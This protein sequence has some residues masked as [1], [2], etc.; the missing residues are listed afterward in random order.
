MKHG[1]SRAAELAAKLYPFVRKQR[2]TC[3]SE[4]ET[5]LAEILEYLH[6]QHSQTSR[7]ADPTIQGQLSLPL[8]TPVILRN[9]PYQANVVME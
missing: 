4:I 3:F 8:D 9:P 6:D 5:L 2:N 1:A 7:S